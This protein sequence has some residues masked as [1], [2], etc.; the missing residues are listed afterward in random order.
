MQTLY[1][2]SHHV[3][4]KL[5]QWQ[6]TA[7]TVSGGGMSGAHPG[8]EGPWGHSVHHSRGPWVSVGG[9]VFCVELAFGIT[10]HIL[11]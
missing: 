7:D 9:P 6:W 3:G 1:W 5:L 11:G 10:I 8:Q 4:D 2:Q